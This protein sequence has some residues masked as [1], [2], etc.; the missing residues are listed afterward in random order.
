MKLESL[1]TLAKWET[2]GM[3]SRYSGWP[4]KM[5]SKLLVITEEAYKKHC[6]VKVTAIHAGLEA[7]MICKKH[8]GMEAISIGPTILSPHSPTEK[9]KIETVGQCYEI[10]ADLLRN[11]AAK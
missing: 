6:N 7:G 8:E 5:D 3:K 1:G 9:C 11:I 10:M 2:S 4:A